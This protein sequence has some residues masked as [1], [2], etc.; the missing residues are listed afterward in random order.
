MKQTF[1]ALLFFIAWSVKLV[2]AQ[3]LETYESQTAGATTFVSNSVTFNLGAG[4]S[5]SSSFFVANLA[6]L[7]YNASNKFVHVN[8]TYGE[9]WNINVSS[10]SF[11]VSSL[12]LYITG[13]AAQ[14]AGVTS[15]GLP[16]SVTFTGKLGA[17]TVFTVTKTSGFATTYT[18]PGNG[19]ALVDFATEGGTDNSN[20][21]ID[22]LE[23]QLSSNYDYCAIDN[24]TWN[25]GVVPVTLTFFTAA[26]TAESATLLKWT[27]ASEINNDRF[28]IERSADGKS[29]SQLAEI[30]GGGNSSKPLSYS[31]LDRDAVSFAT[32]SH[33]AIVYYRLKQVDFDGKVYTYETR[34][35]RM[36][37]KAQLQVSVSPNPFMNELTVAVNDIGGRSFDIEITDLAGK[38]VFATQSVI[39]EGHAEVS[40]PNL[41]ELNKGIYFVAVKGETG[42][43]IHRIV[44]TN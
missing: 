7:G 25:M 11:K 13:N 2:S 28:I 10:G 34:S 20:A 17:T 24:F 36:L 40:I 19:F 14:D 42:T 30:K 5:S 39:E 23:I 12:W 3:T 29:F 27:T 41:D 18:L 43:I 22:K 37:D 33:S 16:G 8:D 4:A 31:Y 44:K 21:I 6:G 15:N 26:K 32:A 9:T 35:V 38:T 1:T